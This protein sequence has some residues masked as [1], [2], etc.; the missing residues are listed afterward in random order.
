ML[1]TEVS[2]HFLPSDYWI[3]GP[4]LKGAIISIGWK[5]KYVYDWELN[6]RINVKQIH[7]RPIQNSA[8]VIIL[9]FLLQACLNYVAVMALL[10]KQLNMFRHEMV[11]IFSLK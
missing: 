3:V 10:N 6:N 9:S 4:V 11:G 2:L 5:L 7:Y 1:I 8:C